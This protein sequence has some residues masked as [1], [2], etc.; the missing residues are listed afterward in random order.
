MNI[1][2]NQFSYFIPVT[3]KLFRQFFIF[4]R[5]QA[6]NHLIYHPGRKNTVFLENIPFALQ[7]NGRGMT[8]IGK[9]MKS[10]PFTRMFMYVLINIQF[11]RFF[12]LFSSSSPFMA[13]IT[14]PARRLCTFADPSGALNSKELY[15]MLLKILRLG[16]EISHFIMT[17]L[18]FPPGTCDQQ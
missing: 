13:P 14:S 11:F 4:I 17:V 12:E 18:Y 15:L 7:G 5:K 3:V 10:I 1:L 6:F 2:Y 16:S 8:G 9:L